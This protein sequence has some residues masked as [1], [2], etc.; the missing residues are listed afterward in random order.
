MR[1]VPEWG[2]GWDR[3]SDDFELGLAKAV[4][5]AGSFYFYSRLRGYHKLN[6]LCFLSKLLL[7]GF[8]SFSAYCPHQ[9]LKSNAAD[10]IRDPLSSQPMSRFTLC[11][12]N[13]H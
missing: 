7:C 1:Q 2:L 12:D 13:G 3:L 11:L 4:S 8:I 9:L 6:V 5:G 10:L